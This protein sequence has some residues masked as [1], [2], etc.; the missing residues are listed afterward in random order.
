MDT[1]R[2]R[3][4]KG[5][6]ADIPMLYN[7]TLQSGHNGKITAETVS[8][9]GG[10]TMARPYN[11]FTEEQIELLRGN[12]YVRSVGE[13]LVF[14]TEEFKRLYWELYT[15]E[16]LMPYEIMRRLGMDYHLL[17]MARVRGFTYNLKKRHEREGD[18]IGDRGLEKPVM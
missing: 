15:V 9:N 4:F 1:Y 12:K 2:V 7:K 17:G 6:A 11:K 3:V 16:N 5:Y 8:G 13:K 18:F 10:F 14:F